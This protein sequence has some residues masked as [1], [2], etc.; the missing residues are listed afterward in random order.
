MPDYSGSISYGGGGRMRGVQTGPSPGITIGGQQGGF[1]DPFSF[2]KRLMALKDRRA[3]VERSRPLM[4]TQNAPSALQNQIL[5]EQA[6]QAKLQTA[7]MRAE[8]QAK[9][10][11]MPTKTMFG[12][13][14]IP[15]RVADPN[16]MNYYQRQAYLPGES[17]QVG[18][19]GP[20]A[21]SEVPLHRPGGFGTGGTDWQ[22]S[23]AQAQALTAGQQA[24]A[25]AQDV[26]FN[27]ARARMYPG[28]VGRMKAVAD[29]RQYLPQGVQELAV[30]STRG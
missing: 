28:M 11:P 16:R 7:M 23:P 9:R 22:T 6:E 27:A 26:S 2:L 4:A 18:G 21:H 8:E 10:R 12:F 20:G 14:V 3:S 25:L 1:Q 15:G 17:T 19:F 13:N 24:N 29:P 5:Q 30:G